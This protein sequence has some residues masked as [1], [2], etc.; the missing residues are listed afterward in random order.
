LKKELNKLHKNGE[1]SI[2]Q[3]INNKLIYLK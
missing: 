3:G 2:K 1:I